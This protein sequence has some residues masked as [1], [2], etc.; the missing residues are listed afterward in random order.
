MA[1]KY[2]WVIEQNCDGDWQPAD[3]R[4]TR[5]AAR[6]LAKYFFADRPTRIRKYI[7]SDYQRA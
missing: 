3:G 2:L 6:R 5:E 4:P 1:T 7:P